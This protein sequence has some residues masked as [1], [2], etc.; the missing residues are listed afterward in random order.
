MSESTYK[1]LVSAPKVVPMMSKITED[2][3]TCPNYLDW[4]KTVCLYLRSI[5]MASHLTED[6]PI[7][8]SKD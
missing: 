2:K 3:Q 5:R 1:K 7:D 8:A 4:N 6:P